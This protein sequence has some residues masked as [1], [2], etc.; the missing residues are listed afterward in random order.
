MVSRKKSDDTPQNAPSAGLIEIIKSHVIT[1]KRIAVFSG[2]KPDIS[3]LIIWYGGEKELLPYMSD[4]TQKA[5]GSFRIDPVNERIIHNPAATPL[6]RMNEIDINDPKVDV[7]LTE[8]NI[9]KLLKDYDLAGYQ[10]LKSSH[11]T[12]Y[13]AGEI[14]LADYTDM[15]EIT[16]RIRL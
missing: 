1:P 14:T 15:K 11:L 12:S 9:L 2:K 5:V 3:S 6:N 7:Y 16:C 10:F 13:K 4:P 8:K